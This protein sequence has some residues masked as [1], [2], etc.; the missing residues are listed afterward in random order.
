MDKEYLKA[1]GLTEEQA[2]KVIAELGKNFVEKTKF[3]EISKE[4]EVLKQSVSERDKQ[5]EDLKKGNK[6]NEELKK[7][8]EELQKANTEQQKAHETELNQI[9]LESVIDKALMSAGAKNLKAVKSLFDMDKLK[10][11]D[12]GEI[13]GLEEQLKGVQKT[14]P[15]MFTEKQITQKYSFKGFT[16]AVSN[17]EPTAN[18]D[19]SK[20]T[21]S[22]LAAYMKANPDAK[23]N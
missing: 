21:Y 11:N 19:T 23:I 12:K 2:D 6:D 7:Q 22:E 8:I 5:L 15:Y 3:D 4:N 14:D 13:E 18:I 20:M 16:P 1:M 10:F 9:K 17:V